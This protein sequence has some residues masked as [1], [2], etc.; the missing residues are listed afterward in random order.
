MKLSKQK[1]KKAKPTI[2]KMDINWF[3][4]EYNKTKIYLI[5]YFTKKNNTNDIRLLQEDNVVNLPFLENMVQNNF[6][7]INGLY[8]VM[9]T[10]KS[11]KN[12]NYCLMLFDMIHKPY[13]ASFQ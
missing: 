12:A 1:T 9:L 3:L 11:E 2:R 4:E 8:E 5:K 13:S 6:I 10:M 7:T